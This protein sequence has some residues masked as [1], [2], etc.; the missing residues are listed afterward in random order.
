MTLKYLVTVLLLGMCFLYIYILIFLLSKTVK[1]MDCCCSAKIYTIRCEYIQR[2][3]IKFYVLL[4][5][6]PA[7][8]L[9]KTFT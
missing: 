3:N 5:S 1:N 6:S 9:G 7:R 8:G 2:E 4:Y